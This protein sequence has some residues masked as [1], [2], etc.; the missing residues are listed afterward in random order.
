[1][2]SGIEIAAQMYTVREYTKTEKDIAA[3]LEKIKEIG[4]DCIQVSA[5]GPCRPEF[6]RDELQ[7]NG[8]TVCATHVPYQRITEDTDNVIKEH[9]IIGAKYVG[10]GY[11]ETRDPEFV[12]TVLSE[13]EPAAKKIK[14]AG[15][16]FVYHNHNLEFLRLENG[17]TAMEY[18]LE[19]TGDEFGLLPDAYW[20]QYAGLSPVKF[21]TD[22]AD[23]IKVI[24]FKDMKVGED[25]APQMA[26][27][28]EG[29]MDYRSIYDAC[30]KCGVEY[31]AVEQDNCYGLDPFE[32]L[33][34]SRDNIKNILGV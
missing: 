13:L 21:I 8:L 32:C 15:L 34:R 17:K 18:F 7:K 20:L 33:K 10:L 16:Q 24:H 3:T 19:N 30:V 11:R 12:K 23:R 31:V 25:G 5:F 28:F 2:K 22:N 4:Y 29:N 26:E 1:M 9:K 6:L 14:D 27:V